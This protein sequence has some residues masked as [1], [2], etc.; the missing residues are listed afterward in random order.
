[1]AKGLHSPH[2]QK[3][4]FIYIVNIFNKREARQ[5]GLVSLCIDGAFSFV[6]L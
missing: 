5:N 3:Y 2:I 4:T 1:V 6:K